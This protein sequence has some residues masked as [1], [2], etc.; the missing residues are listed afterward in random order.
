MRY[1]RFIAWLTVWLAGPVLPGLAQKLTWNWSNPQPHGNDI[2]AMAWNG[3]LGIQVCELGQV[4]TSPDM[5]NWFPQN[6]GL[7]NDLEAVTFFGNRI[8]IAGA[9][10]AVAY[11]DD[12]VNFTANSLNTPN[13][14]VSLAASSNLV[15]AVGDNGALY[16]STNGANWD[17]QSPPPDLYPSWLT[18]VAYGNGVFVTTGDTGGVSG[19]SY[20]ANSSDG[21]HWT[22]QS[23]ANYGLLSG[24]GNLEDVAWVNSSGSDKAYPYTGFWAVD[25]AGDAIYSVNYGATWNQFTMQNS[26]N[27]LYAISADNVTGLLAG[28]SEVRLGGTNSANQVVWPEQVGQALTNVPPWTYFTAVSETNG[29]YELAGYDGM[30][31]QSS[32]ANGGY[33]WNTP[34]YSA[35]D[36]LWQ[37]TSTP[38]FYVAVG[39]NA[40]IM[41]SENGAQWAI[42]EVPLT[43][44][45]SLTNTVFL[46][47]GGTTNLLIAAGNQGS[48]AV[49]PNFLTSLEETND[50]GSLFTN[51]AST[52]GVIWYSLTAPEGTTNDIA[53]IYAYSNS[54]YLVGDK[55]MILSLN[56]TN[57][58]GLNTNNLDALLGGTN[59]T[60]VNSSV[61]NDLS[62]ITRFTNGLL[63]VSGDHG[64][65]LTSP[66]GTDWTKRTT[67]ITSALLRVRCA[68]GQL[69][70]GAE[71][72]TLLTSTN[73]TNWTD[74]STG[75]TN[76]LTDAIMISNACYVVGNN[77]VVLTSTNF[78]DWANIGTITS[79]SLEGV[80]TQNGQLVAVGFE[81]TI[82][83]SQV[84]PITTPVNF[85]TYAQTEGY[86]VFA[87]A[88][89]V[90]QQFTLDSSTNLMG[91]ETGPLLNLS[92]GDGTLIFYQE[93]PT[94]PPDAQYY[95]C[96]LVP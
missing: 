64:R 41:T 68:G 42:E 49:S 40:R 21:I 81:G 34:Y 22:N 38:G 67:G 3:S 96:T 80:A 65:I 36:W 85:V 33:S 61:T 1:L 23:T 95:R 25:D 57:W 89:V 50:D 56:F 32:V 43:N 77:G 91:W 27:V 75:Q 53:G 18:S 72:G 93:L 14:I 79:K 47:V 6:S 86:N 30:L 54:F 10:G 5:V 69:L 8:I 73:G 7:T 16:T 11:S 90:D 59:W 24:L 71:N 29:V 78:E 44:S 15:V 87:V 13:W 17:L 26:T 45:V 39:D 92:Y 70:A 19:G 35:R 62:G 66:D 94:N 88:G 4:Y 84:I 60:V 28:D 55:G 83:R 12:G 58:P 31:V 74:I 63:V 37:V 82:L 46:C 76:L 52:L 51:S 2:V 9:D 20:L 48:L